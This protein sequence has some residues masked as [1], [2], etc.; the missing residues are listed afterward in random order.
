MHSF[1]R[2]KHY[3]LCVT[4]DPTGRF[5]SIVVSRQPIIGLV[6]DVALADMAATAQ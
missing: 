4:F 1:Y 6:R 2:Y 5:V 3:S